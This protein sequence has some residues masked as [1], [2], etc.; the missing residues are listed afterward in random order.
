LKA[1]AQIAQLVT[2][3]DQWSF[4]L[5]KTF[6]LQRWLPLPKRQDDYPAIEA[7][8]FDG[9]DLWVCGSHTV[10]H[11]KPRP[12]DDPE[13]MQSKIVQARRWPNRCLLARMSMPRWWESPGSS[14]S[15]RSSV[16]VLRMDPGPISP[17]IK[18][19]EKHEVLSGFLRVPRRTAS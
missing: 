18:A 10:V 13:T 15:V 19:L 17:L 11:R 4:R 7:I 16:S 2:E 8:D 1:G 14:T 9:S 6:S 3:P 5:E 12:G